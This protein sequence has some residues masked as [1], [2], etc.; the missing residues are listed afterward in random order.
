LS[1]E[2]IRDCKKWKASA[3]VKNQKLS[4]AHDIIILDKKVSDGD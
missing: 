4:E 2:T 1:A 3:D